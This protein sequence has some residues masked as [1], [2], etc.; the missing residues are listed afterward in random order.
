MRRE[1]RPIGATHFVEQKDVTLTRARLANLLDVD[2]GLYALDRYDL[3]AHTTIDAPV[4]ASV[5]AALSSLKDPAVLRK[6]GLVGDR[7]LG[8]ADP[9]KVIYSFTL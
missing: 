2:G 8:S 1:E 9:G 4:Q 3:T 7:L 5:S 6:Y